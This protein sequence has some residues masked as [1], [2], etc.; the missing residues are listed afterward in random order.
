MTKLIKKIEENPSRWHEVL[1]KALWTHDISR[2]KAL[3]E[4]E[5]KDKNRF[6]KA[7]NKKVKS[8]SF[9]MGELVKTILPIGSMCN[10]FGKW[11]LNWED[12]YRVI[13]VIVG[14][15]DLLETLQ[16]EDLNRAFN[17]RYL[18]KYFPSVRQEA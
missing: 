12:P 7:Y 4:I 11:S 13:K 6:A 8:K 16:G 14:N 10:E 18:T 2:L 15:S 5:K 9:Q 17:E 3:K 1:S